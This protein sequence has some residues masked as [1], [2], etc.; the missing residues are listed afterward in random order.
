MKAK[1]IVVLLLSTVIGCTVAKTYSSLSVESE[2]TPEVKKEKK[3]IVKKQSKP[4]AVSI[5]D[6]VVKTTQIENEEQ[7]SS[8]KEYASKQKSGIVGVYGGNTI[9]NPEDNIFEVSIPSTLTSK[10]KVV[11]SYDVEGVVGSTGVALSVND[12]T[13]LGGMIAYASDKVSSVREEINS[14]WIVNGKNRF[15]FTLPDSAN[16]GYKISNLKVSVASNASSGE[17]IA[18]ATGVEGQVYVKGFV[19]NTNA[20]TINIAG[21][22]YDLTNG[23]FEALISSENNTVSIACGN[24]NRMLSVQS[25]PGCDASTRLICANKAEQQTQ[26]E[27]SLAK[28]ENNKVENESATLNVDSGVSK[29]DMKITMTNLRHKDLPALDLGMSNVTDGVDGYR[30]LPHGVHFDGKGAV[31]SLKY[32]RTKIPSGYTENDIRTYYF[33]L[34]TKHWVALKR[35]SIDKENNL[36]VSHTNHFTDMINGVIQAPESPE[37]QGFTP[38]MMS[39][40]KLAD[41]TAKIQ[42][43]Q[44]PKANN[45]GSAN[46]S[47]SF[48]MPP[49]R[50]GMQPSLGIQYNSDGGTGLLGEGWDMSVPTISVETRWGVP[51]YEDNVESETYNMDGQ[52]LVLDNN[53]ENYLAHRAEKQISRKT[54]SVTFHPRKEGSFSKIQ[55]LGDKP[56]EYTWVVTDKIGTKYYYGMKDADGNM[57]GVLKGK[58]YLNKEVIAEW[59]LV[60]IEEVHGDWVEYNY[61]E[62]QL[63]QP[64]A[65]SLRLTSVSA[66]NS[67]CDSHTIVTFIYSHSVMD[68]KSN[69]TISSKTIT[70][71]RYGFLSGQDYLLKE[72]SVYYENKNHPLRS[73]VFDY[74][75]GQ[76]ETVLLS[77]VRHMVDENE[78]S[79]NTFDY[80]NNLSSNGDGFKA[81]KTIDVSNGDKIEVYGPDFLAKITNSLSPLGTSSSLSGSV[82]VYGGVGITDAQ[83]TSKSNSAGVVYSFSYSSSKGSISYMDIDGDGLSDMVFKSGSDKKIYYRPCLPKNAG[84]GSPIPIDGISELSQ[85]SSITNTIG[86]KGHVGIGDALLSLGG[87]FGFSEATTT[88]Y[89]SDVNGDGLVDLVTDEEVMFN[90]LEWK[91]EY[92]RFVPVFK[93]GS[94]KTPNPINTSGF[95][96]T[97][98]QEKQKDLDAETKENAKQNPMHDVVRVWKAPYEGNVIISGNAKLVGESADGVVISVQNEASLINKESLNENGAE[99]SFLPQ[100][101]YVKKGD[102]LFFRIQSGDKFNSNGEGDKVK[103]SPVVSYIEDFGKDANG[104]SLSKYDSEKDFLLQLANYATIESKSEYNEYTK[105][106]FVLNVNKKVNL[107]DIFS[108]VISL[109]K[110]DVQSQSGDEVEVKSITY[111]F[112]EKIGNDEKIIE[113]LYSYMEDGYVYSLSC[114]L[115]TKSNIDFNNIDVLP[116][117]EYYN[118][119]SINPDI[120]NL[121]PGFTIYANNVYLGTSRTIA[122][123]MS[124]I[125]SGNSGW[126]NGLT[127]KESEDNSDNMLVWKEEHIVSVDKDNVEKKE[128]VEVSAPISSVKSEFYVVPQFEYTETEGNVP[129]RLVV[130]KDGKCEYISFGLIDGA[131]ESVLLQKENSLLAEYLLGNE[132]TAV[133]DVWLEFYPDTEDGVFDKTISKS[134]LIVYAKHTTDY[135]YTIVDA[136]GIETTETKNCIVDLY[137]SK[138]ENIA[139][140]SVVSDLKYGP[141]Y[142]NWG[143]FGYIAN[144]YT[145]EVDGGNEGESVEKTDVRYENPLDLEYLTNNIYSEYLDEFD[146]LDPDNL[147]GESLPKMD[148]NKNA[149]VTLTPDADLKMWVG[150]P[151]NE[152][153]VSINGVGKD[154][155]WASRTGKQDVEAKDPMARFT[156]QLSSESGAVG[157]DLISKSTSGN[158]NVGLFGYSLNIGWNGDGCTKTGFFDLN[159]DGYPDIIENGRIRFTNQ[160]GG[161]SNT[162]ISSSNLLDESKSQGLGLG[163]GG[164]VNMFPCNSKTNGA[165]SV[166][167]TQ[168]KNELSS[169]ASCSYGGRIQREYNEYAMV[170]MNGDGLP[171]KVSAYDKDL[172]VSLNSGYGFGTPVVWGKGD[173]RKSLSFSVNGGLGFNWSAKS[174]SAGLS[175]SSSTTNTMRD[176]KDVNGDGLPDLVVSKLLN[177][178]G[179]SSFPMNLL[180]KSDKFNDVISEFAGN[181]SEVYINTGNGFEKID[182]YEVPLLGISTSNSGSINGNFTVG[183][184]AALLVKIVA[185]GG[186]AASGA[187]ST[188]D[189]MLS[190]YDGD[191][192]PDVLQSDDSSINEM[193]LKVQL[194][195]I[196]STNKLKS[197]ETP[198]GGKYELSYIHSTPTQQ[199]PGGKWVM[200]ELKVTDTKRDVEDCPPTITKFEYDGGKRDRRER[201]FYGF[202]EVKTKMMNGDKVERQIVQNYDTTNYYTSG[203]AIAS[204]VCDASNQ[205]FSKDTTELKMYS[206]SGQGGVETTTVIGESS[207]IFV[208]PVKATSMRFEKND[209]DGVVTNVVENEYG[210]FGN[211]TK[212]TYTDGIAKNGYTTTIAYKPI[213]KYGVFGLPTDVKVMSGEKDEN[214]EYQDLMRHVSAEYDNSGYNPSSM[215]KMT[216]YLGEETAEVEFKYDTLGKIVE[217]IMPQATGDNQ[218]KERMKFTYEY[219][220]KLGMYPTRVTDGFGYRSDMFN[221][222][223][224]YGIPLSVKDMNGFITE[225][226]IDDLGR[227]VK[228]TAPNELTANKD[229]TIKYEYAVNG[230]VNMAKTY[231]FDPQHESDPMITINIVDG[232]GRELQAR[233]NA[234][235]R[236]D[237]N[238][239]IVSGKTTFDALGR[240]VSHF[241]PTTCA[242]SDMYKEEIAP[243]NIKLDYKVYDPFDRPL[244]SVVYDDASNAYESTMSYTI[245]NDTLATT[246]VDPEGMKVSSYTDGTEH[247]LKTI[248]YH[249][250]D[251]GENASTHF[252]FDGI[253]QLLS[254]TDCKGVVTS[255]EYDIAGRKLSVEHPSAGKTSFTYDNL[256]NVITK[257]TAKGDKVTYT[258][259][260][261]RLTKQ[262]YGDKDQWKNEVRYTYGGVDA[263][264]NRVG[265]LALVEDGSG[266]QEYFYGKMGEVEKIRRT[267]IIPGVDVATYTTEWKYDS[268]NRVQEMVYPDGEKLKYYYNLGGQL[269]KITGEKNYLYT[270]ID[271]IQYDEYEQRSLV[272]YGNGTT[273]EYKYEKVL[274]RLDTMRVSNKVGTFLNNKYSYDKVNNVLGVK[275]DAALNVGIG[276]TMTHTYTYDDWHR[277]KTADGEFVGN[278]NK[279]ANY[280]LAMG[281]DNLYNITSKK[282][283][284]SQTN[285]QFD[286]TLSAGHNFDYKYSEDNPMKLLSVETKQYNVDGTVADSEIETELAKNQRTQSYDFDAN[287]N[288]TSTSVDTSGVLKSFLWD[289]ENR[290]LAVNNNGSVSCYFYD[291]AGERTVKLTS[292]SE[293]VHV[294]GKKTGGS[295]SVT[296]FTAYVSPYFVVSNGGAYTKHI[297][298][299]GQRIASKLGN[300][301]GFGADPRRVEQ[302]GGLK[303]EDDLV[304]TIKAR[305]DSL[306]IAYS[307]QDKGDVEKDSTMDSEENESLVFFYHPDHL[308]STSYVTDADGNIAQHVEYIPYGEVF[309]EERNSQFSTNYLF[310]AKEL[311]N[312]TGLYY[313]GARYLD[314]TGAMWLSVD[315]LFEKYAGMSPYNYCAGNPVKLVDPDGNAIWAAGAAIGGAIIGGAVNG[316]LTAMDPSKSK[317][318]VIAS[319]VGG[320]VSGAIAAGG[321]SVGA[322]GV[323][324]AVGSGLGN[325][326]EQGINWLFDDKKTSYDFGETAVAVGTGALC[327]MAARGTSN[328]IKKNVEEESKAIAKDAANKQVKARPSSDYKANQRNAQRKNISPQ[329]E[330]VG[331][332]KSQRQS[333]RTQSDNKISNAE[334]KGDVYN[335]VS[336]V[337]YSGSQNRSQNMLV[338]KCKLNE[339]INAKIYEKLGQ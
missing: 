190:D 122:P 4:E 68:V 226:E 261:S 118:S 112:D 174:I 302:A 289:E 28:N 103:W 163:K 79:K 114:Q 74:Q 238:V 317:V 116:K 316:F 290:L 90:R 130:K 297:Y 53:G 322:A 135:T 329:Q 176:L 259:E 298:T 93:K 338:E 243:S 20:K 105:A 314:P 121:V 62:I 134:E 183:I 152:S 247:T 266:A 201:D 117:I 197:V 131:Y 63:E 285:L 284:M 220:K 209:K 147:D 101:E 110:T 29:Q 143:Q 129:V 234:T 213:D 164:T 313:Y 277:L 137:D 144:E 165:G 335:Y 87:D 157:I 253:G 181:L 102:R 139:F 136:S 43:I 323:S 8:Y 294:N 248:K 88:V 258:Y 245:E 17:M 216:Q 223:Y 162:C 278:D 160:R 264:H 5:A 155:M 273:T 52:M 77:S 242:K 85:S 127:V 142:R 237:D 46:L 257:E 301:D 167:Q 308:G 169:E 104:L 228:V 202:C 282:M 22:E 66:G 239:M 89:F 95:T 31:V 133:S 337:F 185:S 205:M 310:N 107:T 281:Y 23:A 330:R 175:T 260:F 128:L 187:Y 154:D 331:Q 296:K 318:N 195:K 84:F 56:S 75:K 196:G 214:G 158:S 94:S 251:G 173:I 156:K 159:A 203:T 254:V 82:D 293:M 69:K 111:D 125:E 15:M 32:D 271:D 286:G 3:S 38:T 39:D 182:S 250:K 217:K 265:R 241:A 80:Y 138:F 6:T 141:M 192:F 276:G 123:V 9:D 33:D 211:L 124:Q 227:I 151:K 132:G 240:E 252:I 148:E 334:L 50:N 222:D 339:K 292:E 10:D 55:R 236:T 81:T 219:D 54:G 16:Y 188:T 303:K 86:G 333:I 70:N 230:K 126:L 332:V 204:Y 2:K 42:S 321:A 233:K 18:T 184:P 98:D 106:R 73:Y 49:A 71:G 61:K 35:D 171:D 34:D 45:R 92:N 221:Y 12:H 263:K 7:K 19:K 319:I 14:E 145:H 166:N 26:K 210:D 225:Y 67:G 21:K 311:D 267:L 60:R 109:K 244:S 91:E 1:K 108:I 51:R 256:G 180:Q 72:V 76:F 44:P 168:N 309:V 64:A 97:I 119:A 120:K 299:A 255:Y 269:N 207:R 307:E 279:S 200:S 24:V 27:F 246:I 262:S 189:C 37:T 36:I 140:H 305:F 287:G 235:V 48:E 327:N 291:A 153:G 59:K 177:F 275:N 40:L 320:A 326:I 99:T 231:H 193:K 198:F 208:A 115:K 272:K 268:W 288:M 161:F 270:Y 315:P 199:H 280:H 30:F 232:L 274:R 218:M 58:N 336:D 194:S 215:T 179:T 11:I 324:G 170:D 57:K 65:Q 186:G 304:N 96:Y 224:R 325:A 83:F 191:G 283:T 295:E 149:F 47:Y 78:I 328:L 172:I 100:T 25:M 312:E 229:Y 113:D 146:G 178:P 306:G 41:P 150:V 212:Y 300:I 206:V 13:A 249:T